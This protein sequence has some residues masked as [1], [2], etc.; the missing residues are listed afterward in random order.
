[1]RPESVRRPAAAARAAS[2]RPLSSAARRRTP[3]WRPPSSGRSP[4]RSRVRCPP[5]PACPSLRRLPSCSPVR[6]GERS[7]QR[8][9]DPCDERAPV[10]L[11]VLALGRIARPPPYAELLLQL[12]IFL[13]E[14]EQADLLVEVRVVELLLEVGH[15]AL[16]A[17][18]GDVPVGLDGALRRG[19]RHHEE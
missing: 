16:G 14:P 7:L 18:L 5:R 9:V 12:G 8:A 19:A 15:H 17:Q 11:L 6:R 13:A 1:M 2:P 4:P 3:R 10:D